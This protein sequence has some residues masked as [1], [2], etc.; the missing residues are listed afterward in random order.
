RD[1]VDAPA[2]RQAARVARR[3]V[4]DV[5]APR[6]VRVDAVEGRQGR[7]VERSRRGRRERIRQTAVGGPEGPGDERTVV[8]QIAPRRVVERDV[9]RRGRRGA[10]HVRPDRGVLGRTGEQHVDVIG[11]GGR[12]AEE[13][14]R[15]LAQDRVEARGRDRRRVRQGSGC[16]VTDRD[17]ALVAELHR[18]GNRTG[19]ADAGVAGVSYRADVAVGAGSG[20]GGVQTAV[21][22]IAGIGRTDVVVVAVD[23]RVGAAPLAVA[24]VVGAGVVVIAGVRTGLAGAAAA[25]V[26]T[27]AG[28][29]VLARVAVGDPGAG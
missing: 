25:S 27:G 22:R 13:V 3:V 29:A 10:A 17:Q 5:E 26:G 12:E 23:G 7:D 14:D 6:A 4:D 19:H 11:E 18:G 8:G 9:H 2:A 15:S 1:D 24:D 21:A 20:D 16:A 28:I